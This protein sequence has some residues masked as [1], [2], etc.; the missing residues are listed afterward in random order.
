MII[1]RKKK[2]PAKMPMI[3]LSR[4][5]NMIMKVE[6]LYSKYFSFFLSNEFFDI[7][8]FSN[9]DVTICTHMISFFIL[10]HHFN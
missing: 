2:V 9:I 10:K 5:I 6:N 4:H 7:I 3:T 8:F 1:R